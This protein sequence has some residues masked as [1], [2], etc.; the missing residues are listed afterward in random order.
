MP[1]LKTNE[2]LGLKVLVVDDNTTNRQ[3][4]EAFLRKL[5]CRVVEAVDGAQ[6]VEVFRREAPDLILMD[7][8][9]PVM[10][11]Y[12]A[13]RRIKELASGRWVPVVFL[14][15]LDKDESLVTGLAAGGDDYLAKPANLV[16]LTAKL[17]SFARTLDFQRRLDE[18]R[19]LT[20]A[21]FDN[22]D[23]CVITID[24]HGTIMTSN[25]ALRT[26]FGYEAEE[27][28]GRN[29]EMLMPE[30]QR[31]KHRE[32]LRRYVGGAAPRM[33]GA[34]R[35][36]L[37]GL[38]K[39]GREVLLEMGVTEMR[40]DG[41]RR[42]VGIMR[43]ITQ[44]ASNERRLREH[45][46][47]LQRYHDDREA[48]NALAGE[49]MDRLLH[50]QGLSDPRVRYWL[51]PASEFS[52]D[53][54]AAC[55]SPR[56]KFYVML[57]D[58]TGHGLAAA[59]SL[60]P[61]LTNFYALAEHD[62]PLG[63]IAYEMNRQL[64][65]FMPTGRFVAAGLASLNPE[66]HVVDV[67][68]GGVPELLL[69]EP[70]GTVREGFANMHLPL[71]IVDFDED[72]SVIQRIKCPPGSQLVLYSD[73]LSESTNSAGEPFGVTR[74]VEALA[75]VPADQRLEAVKKAVLAHRGDMAGYDDVSLLLID[76]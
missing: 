43:D 12:E 74:L 15:A 34:E 23:D 4:L 75:G 7:V 28:A 5:G 40:V 33:V 21:I 14:S 39:D 58:A 72:A 3:M 16:V 52:G 36:E 56:G 64:M 2:P 17:R 60:L 30:S 53:I 35:I 69:V 1:D 66:S 61:V 49:I 19:R 68:T 46:A 62:Y 51:M 73:G 10:D 65:A 27:V 54:V 6:A 18:S 42:F 41:Q 71:G 11:G 70:D 55:F 22:I 20:Q 57:A 31:E 24:E 29:V 37:P 13:T 44:R 76:C 50:R 9:M 48:E 8:M 45:A 63:F 25:A 38:C 26:I 67:W 32:S 59:I 47:A